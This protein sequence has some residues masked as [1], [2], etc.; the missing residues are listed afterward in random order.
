MSGMTENA[1]VK[2]FTFRAVF[3]LWIFLCTTAQANLLQNPGFEENGGSGGGSADH[4]TKTEAAGI[5]TWAARTDSWGMSIVTWRGGGTGEVYQ[6]VSVTES[7]FCIYKIW[8]RRDPDTFS[9]Q[10]YMKIKWYNGSTYLS[11]SSKNITLSSSSWTQQTLE[12]T[13]PASCDTARIIFGSVAVTQVGKF[14][15]ASFTPTIAHSPS[16][17]DGADYVDPNADLGWQAGI[18]AASHDV[19]F[20]T[21][22]NDVNEADATFLTGDVDNDSEVDW[23]DIAILS[24]QWLTIPSGSPSADIAGDSRVNLLDF[25]VMANDWMK[26]SAFKGNQT[27]TSFEP[28][29]MDVNTTYYW[30]IDEVSGVDVWQGDVWSFTVSYLPVIATGHD[31]RIDLRWPFDANVDGYNIYRSASALGP[32]SKQNSSLYAISVY[33][34]FFGTNDETYF[35]YVTTVLDGEE[36]ATSRIVSATSYAMTDEELLDSVQEAHFRFFWDYGHPVSGLAREAYNVNTEHT[37]DHCATGGSGMGLMAICVGI[38]RGFVTRADAAE[39]LL[40]ILTFLEEDAERYHGAWAHWINGTTGETIP[41]SEYDDGGD[42]IETAFMMQGMLTVREYFDAN[43]SVETEIRSRVTSM[44]EDLDWYWYLRRTDT[45]YENSEWLYWHWSE[46]YDWHMGMPIGGWNEGMIPYIL[47][48]A[49]PTHPIPASCYYNGWAGSENFPNGNEYYGYKQW[50]GGSS[51]YGGNL[52]WTHYS[53]L[54]FDPNWSDW[55]CNYFDN[56][57]NISLIQRAYADA[58]PG[59]FVGHSDLVW[60]FT[61]CYGPWGYGGHSIPA[62]DDGTI[63]PTAALSAMAY[64]PA[65]SLATMKHLYHTYG[66]EGLWGAFGFVDAFN[67][68]EDPNWFAQ[69]YVAIDQGPIVVMMENSRTGLCWDLFMANPEIQPALDAIA[70]VEF[71]NDRLGNPNVDGSLDVSGGIYTVTGAGCDFWGNYDEGHYAY[72]RLSGDCQITARVVSMTN[73]DYWAKAGV[74]IRESRYVDSKCV[75]MAMTPDSKNA[76]FQWRSTTGGDTTAS[77]QYSLSLPYWVRLVRVGDTFKAYRS[78][79]GTSW[80]QQGS[81][82]TISMSEDIYIGL[83]VTS[84]SVGN[85]CTAVFGNVDIQ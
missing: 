80:T 32:F 74:M 76:T 41:F 44:W 72:R 23:D 45:G 27:E 4:W 24:E 1:K 57:R 35:Y 25:A 22:F 85:L 58:N 11:E 51:P 73:T 12:A 16:P 66:Q 48:V 9:G 36:S 30:R 34:D 20:G 81:T 78:S 39:R 26:T 10:F 54:G 52:F 53:Y 59:G 70:D 13:S 19:Y 83:A 60:G 42:L 56:N 68:N 8:T 15:D 55:Y 64:T 79:N 14:D 38:E 63:A 5:E 50:V 67:L 6:D 47:A 21:D 77:T 69:G 37:D 43:D 31:S 84:H 17:A 61:S 2:T 40:K 49:S 82:Q 3:F 62:E 7:T 65:E 33:S 71:A 75:L 18:Y 28:G 29:T 46:N